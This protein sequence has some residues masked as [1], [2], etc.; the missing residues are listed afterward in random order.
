MNVCFCV[1]VAPM[2]WYGLCIVPLCKGKKHDCET[3][4]G[5]R[6]LTVVGKVYSLILIE[7]MQ[8]LTEGVVRE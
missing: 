4:R 5:I 8:E 1:G 2:D 7:R 6:L 3:L